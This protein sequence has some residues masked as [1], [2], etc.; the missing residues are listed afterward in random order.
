MNLVARQVRRIVLHPGELY[1]GEGPAIVET[2]LGSCL[3]VVLRN[4]VS[5]FAAMSHCML[6]HRGSAA[7]AL[8]ADPE[9]YK[10][11][12]SC[13]PMMLHL[14]A[15]HGGVESLEVKVFG[16]ADMF[17]PSLAGRAS[18]VGAENAAVALD[19]L[20]AQNLRVLRK[21]L[22]GTRGRKIR[23]DTKTGDVFVRH[24]RSAQVVA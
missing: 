6:P 20:Q 13:I 3:S 2:V 7:K 23:F 17:P 14:M 1:F 10:Y 21:D 15:G 12:D 24:L 5:G 22:G 11:V 8:A 19:R 9:A 18:A 4:P 16:G